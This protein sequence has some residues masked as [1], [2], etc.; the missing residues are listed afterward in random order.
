MSNVVE[1]RRPDTPCLEGLARCCACQHEWTAVAPHG[2]QWLECPNC[3]T[4]KGLYRYACLPGEGDRI[5]VCG[6]GCDVLTAY[7]HQRLFRLRCVSCG[8]D[9]TEAVFG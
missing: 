3:G 8:I 9:H 2:A 7:L 6:C 1:F 4:H 5:F